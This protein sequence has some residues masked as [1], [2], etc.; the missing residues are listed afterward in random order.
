MVV[1]QV[2][3][4]GRAGT[5]N[6]IHDITKRKEAEEALQK[7]ETLFR[8]FIDNLPAQV[9]VKDTTGRFIL[10][11]RAWEK[12]QGV[13]GEEATGRTVYDIFPEDKADIFAAQDQAVLE[14]GQVYDRELELRR[15]NRRLFLHTIKF[16]I[17][18]ADGEVTAI[19]GI[20]TDITEHKRAERLFMEQ[21]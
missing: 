11:N 5:M 7:S 8:S 16:P 10:V 20:A 6:I 21:K 2:T 14:T 13:S 15:G 18:R 19:G 3:W 4:D 9:F 1:G 12:N 17:S